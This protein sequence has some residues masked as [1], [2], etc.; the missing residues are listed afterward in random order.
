MLAG[1]E[2]RK[3][4]RKFRILHT[5]AHSITIDHLSAELEYSQKISRSLCDYPGTMDFCI[6][7]I[8]R[9]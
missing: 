9:R 7:G 2:G 3:D 8:G 4:G 6:Q 5:C 1:V